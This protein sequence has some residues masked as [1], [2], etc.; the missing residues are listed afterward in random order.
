MLPDRAGDEGQGDLG[1]KLLAAVRGAAVAV[2]L[3]GNGFRWI[4]PW[5]STPGPARRS[6]L[7]QRR[8][9]RGELACSRS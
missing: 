8:G 3:R 2:R 9:F 6:A 1:A 5:H 4:M 7:P